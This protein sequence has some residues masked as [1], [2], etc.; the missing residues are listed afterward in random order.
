[1]QK[2]TTFLW[3]DDNAEQAVKFYTSIFKNS[4]ITQISRRP[5]SVAPPLLGER[6][7]VRGFV[8][9]DTYSGPKKNASPNITPPDQI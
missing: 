5:A 3:F 4:K 1:M 9:R 8:S 6:A 7:G 2:I